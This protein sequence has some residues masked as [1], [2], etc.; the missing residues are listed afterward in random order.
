MYH[1]EFIAPSPLRTRV[2]N[3]VANINK[4][5]IYTRIPSFLKHLRAYTFE[6]MQ[7]R[8]AQSFRWDL[9][10]L[11]PPPARRQKLFRD[12]GGVTSRSQIFTN[13][14]SKVLP[15]TINFASRMSDC[16][17]PGG[18][19]VIS[20]L[21]HTP[22][23]PRKSQRISHAHTA[24]LAQPTRGSGKSPMSLEFFGGD[25]KR[26]WKYF[27]HHHH[28]HTLPDSSVKKVAVF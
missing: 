15:K 19:F 26:K 18:F 16:Q 8:N 25:F 21:L 9:G 6:G 12:F 2:L 10:R 13:Y 17:D 24:K 1:F 27:D 28:T 4:P 11:P 3:F 5:T 14:F 7:C 23:P 20:T 22:S